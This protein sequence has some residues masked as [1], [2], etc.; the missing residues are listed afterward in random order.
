MDWATPQYS[1][2]KVNWA[3]QML[4]RPSFIQQALKSSIELSTDLRSVRTF[5]P[6]VA[7]SKLPLR[8]KV[9]LGHQLVAQPSSVYG[10]ANSALGDLGAI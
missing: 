10:S 7:V 3:G 4:G 2:K 8:W 9:D 5:L 1:K 6:W